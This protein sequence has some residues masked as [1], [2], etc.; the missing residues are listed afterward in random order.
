MGSSKRAPLPGLAMDRGARILCSKGRQASRAT[1]PPCLVQLV[2][3]I[4][5]QYR[6]RW[7]HLGGG[8]PHWEGWSHAACADV[9]ARV[10]GQVELGA[11]APAI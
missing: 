1:K 3:R 11:M 8:G 10:M 4:S 9:Q 6:V 5:Q 7:I 2:F